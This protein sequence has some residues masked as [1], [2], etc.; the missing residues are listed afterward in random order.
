MLC[1]PVY[2]GVNSIVDKV[3]VQ[4]GLEVTYIT[5]NSIEDY[6]KAIKPN[7]KVH[8][9]ILLHES[10]IEPCMHGIRPLFR[11]TKII[12]RALHAIIQFCSL[13][14]YIGNIFLMLK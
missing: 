1:Q 5:G 4:L 2:G 6:R 14:F 13:S 9:V 7:T 12:I 11:G 8:T 3:L 10:F